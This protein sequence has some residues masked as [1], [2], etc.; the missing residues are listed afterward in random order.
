MFQKFY[1][2][3]LT[4]IIIFTYSFSF[5]ESNQ[6]FSKGDVELGFHASFNNVQY[7]VNDEKESVN[8]LYADLE[9]SYYLIDNWSIGIS[10]A[11]FYLPEVNDFTGYA[12]GLELNTRYHFQIHDRFIPYLGAHAGYYYAYGDTDGESQDDEAT[13]YGLHTG[14]KIPINENVFF[15]TQLKWTEYDLPWD[16]IEISTIQVLMGLKI[17]F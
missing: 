1:F 12:L 7:E 10:T 13:T 15:D 9:A 3:L 6:Y 8:L 17:V 5:A 2:Y 11:W 4:L 16:Y 14:F